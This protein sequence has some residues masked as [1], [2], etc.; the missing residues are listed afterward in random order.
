[1]P[2]LIEAVALGRPI[3]IVE[4]EKKVEALRQIGI[5]AT[6]NVGGANK[7]LPHYSRYLAGADVVLVPDN[8]EPG[9][10]HI[11]QIGASLTGIAAR[12][13]VLVLPDLPPK[14]DIVD[15]AEA[16]GT[17]EEL[18]KLIEVAPDWQPPAAEVDKAD[19][20]KSSDEA[21]ATAT[22]TENELLEAL[23]RM[24]PGVEFARQ[25][26]RV[27]RDLGVP[28]GAIDDE[29]EARRSGE[30]ATAPLHGWWIVEPWPGP[31]DS[32]S[33]LRDIIARLRRHIVISEDD[34]LAIALWIM[35][36]WV[37]DEVATHSPILN[38]NSAEPES[39]KSTTLGLISFLA[40]QCISSV[41]ISEAALYRAIKL[42]QPSFAIDEFDSVLA[43][44]D[45]TQL[46]SVINSG[47]TRGQGVLRCVGDEKTPE[48][49]S[50]FCP[51]AIGMCGRKL[52]AATLSRCIFVDLKR[53]RST[54]NVER[55]EHKD[56]AGLADLRRRL[57]RW[58]MDNEETL[59]AAAPS[60]PAELTNRRAD[61]WRLQL[62]IAELALADWS[63]KARAAALKIEGKADVRTI[64]VRL[65]ADIRK[66]FDADPAVHCMLSQIMVEKLVE[67]PEQPWIEYAKGKPLTQ[68]R[69]AK[70]LGA[71]SI[72]STTVHPPG[73]KHGKGYY[74]SQVRGDLDAL[75]ADCLRAV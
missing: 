22:A 21:K 40:P 9:W 71:Y 62:A 45:K 39:G 44:E 3:L 35:L 73:L 68:N 11:N 34:G 52:P 37:H 32:D 55:F 54:E 24:P 70:L 69:L 29:L 33:L 8:D 23:A 51:K 56:D 63:E 46:R 65:L 26:A 59:R 15:W 31:V 60:M 17:R 30:H 20:K 2:E 48:L 19:S 64:G 75:L 25:R 50:T 41:E 5:A 42:W 38:V 13:R 49:F 74:R 61:N 72:I 10:Q 27:A 7:W 1:M 66:L 57:K 58:A 14:G 53:K 28:R 36:A 16:G 4:G 12:V 47:H 43:S 18:D 6:C 67:D